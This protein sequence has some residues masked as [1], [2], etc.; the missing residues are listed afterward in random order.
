MDPKVVI[1]ILNWN[2]IEDTTECLESLRVIDYP[3]YEVV[4]VDNGSEGDDVT[5]LRDR[6]GDWIHLIEE[7]V[8]L[9]FCD[10]NNVGM[11]YAVD[12]LDPQYVLLLNNDTVV[13]PEFLTYL[14]RTADDSEERLLVGA[15]I[16]FYDDPGKIQSAGG[17]INHWT[18]DCRSFGKGE[19]DASLSE[20]IVMADFV[21]GCC[22]LA[23]RGVIDEIGLLDPVYYVGYEDSD[24]CMRARKAGFESVICLRAKIWHKASASRRKSTRFRMYY[25]P[26]NQF[27]FA[28]RHLTKPQLT[29]SVAFFVLRWPKYGVEYLIH[30]RDVRTLKDFGDAIL[31]IFRGRGGRKRENTAGQK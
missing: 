19:A 10:G 28:R 31:D 4:V 15:K 8:N 23:S 21:S 26:R 27:I 5:I 13:D 16:L 3:N 30:H 1:V 24:Y 11:R 20:D 6:F 25:R 7:D 9:G 2:G 17:M 12:R 29:A 18:A 14:V 22:L